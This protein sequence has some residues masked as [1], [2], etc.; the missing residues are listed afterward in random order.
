M[1][2]NEPNW[3]DLDRH[4]ERLGITREQL[5]A[6]S[7]IAVE[8]INLTCEELELPETD[9]EAPPAVAA[10]VARPAGPPKPTT[11]TRTTHITI[12]IPTGLLAAYKATAADLRIG[13]QTLIVRTLSAALLPGR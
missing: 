5:A 8:D 11:E 12:R 10:A 1:H 6:A 4:L 2:T 13:Y 3:T 7:D 9:L